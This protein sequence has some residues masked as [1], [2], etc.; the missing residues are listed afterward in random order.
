MVAHTGTNLTATD[1]HFD[2]ECFFSVI[3]KRIIWT[4]KNHSNV[5]EPISPQKLKSR[6]KNVQIVRE[7]NEP[8]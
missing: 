6:D 3:Y 5:D 1:A 4:F 2:N 8:F 7:M